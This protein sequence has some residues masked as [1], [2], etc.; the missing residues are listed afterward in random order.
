MLLTTVE[1]CSSGPSRYETEWEQK[2]Q[3]YLSQFVIQTCKNPAANFKVLGNCDFATEKF[4]LNLSAI[5]KATCGK[6]L[7]GK[8]CES[9]LLETLFAR[10]Q[11]RCPYGN[12]QATQLWCQANPEVCNFRSWQSA[13]L[14]EAKF[15]TTHNQ[16]IHDVG[17]ADM[18]DIQ[19]RSDLDAL[20]R[21]KA[22]L[23][24]L[25]SMQSGGSNYMQCTS[26]VFG[27][28]VN[29]NCH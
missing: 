16:Y 14:F 17:M 3:T 27:N 6:T 13:D 7:R 22:Y 4:Y 15:C 11:L 9:A 5:K 19:A 29:T 1:G 21:R 26:T 12:W 8:K 10:Y 18:H 24:T 28:I 2:K 23:D 20:E 25:Q